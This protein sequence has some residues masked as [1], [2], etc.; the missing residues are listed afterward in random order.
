[1]LKIQGEWL[2]DMCKTVISNGMK[3][4]L[5]FFLML[6]S[7]SYGAKLSDKDLVNVKDHIP[8]IYIDLRY[9]TENNFTGE[10]IYDFYDAYLRYGTVKKLKIVQKELNKLGYSLKIWDA[11]RPTEAQFKLWDAVGHDSRFV[12]NPTKYYSPHSL[13]NTVDITM[14]T[15]DGKEIEMPT[16][17]D[18]FNEKADRNYNDLTPIQRKNALIL[19]NA[20]KK[21]DFQGYRR[22]WW[23]YKDSV[24]YPVI[25][26]F[27]NLKKSLK[28]ENESKKNELKN[29]I[30]LKESI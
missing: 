20:M 6:M 11:Y 19:E 26:N 25:K 17:F 5:M 9:A 21:V 2:I 1:M 13:G 29:Y 4:R 23:H 27:T 16:E 22:E 12:V 30:E 8:N 18:T 24:K 7:L 15:I 3:I 28:S 10:K 14:V